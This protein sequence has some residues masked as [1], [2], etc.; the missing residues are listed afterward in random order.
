MGKWVSGL[1]YAGN[2]IKKADKLAKKFLSEAKRNLNNKDAFY[3]SLHRSLHNYLKAKLQIEA[4]EFSKEK[5]TTVFEENKIN[6]DTTINFVSLIESCDL[7]RFTPISSD[8]M[9]Q[10]YDNA[11]RVISEID[12]AL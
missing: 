11:V 2:K 1:N 4:T 7:A 6:A 8:A 9:Q 5:I 12:K 10:D 3:E